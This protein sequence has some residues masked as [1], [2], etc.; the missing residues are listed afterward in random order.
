MDLLKN[1]KNMVRISVLAVIS[2]LLMLIEIPLFFTP[3]FLKIDISDLPSLVAAFA[4]GPLAGVI[5]ELLKN[6]LKIAIRGTNTVFIGELANF[7]VGSIYV[8][9]SS[10]IYRKS[11]TKKSAVIGLVFGTISM[12]VVASIINYFVLIPLYAK[13]FGW[14]LEKIIEM[15]K[16]VNKF[17]VDLRTFVIFGVFPF[18]ILKGILVGVLGYPL[19]MRIRKSIGEET[20]D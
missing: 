1:R 19:Y 17:V 10:Y 2:F 20:F 15:A 18:N 11:K 5:V 13:L 16:A 7:I 9:V 12:A 6:I 3:E 8:V 14:P 4:M